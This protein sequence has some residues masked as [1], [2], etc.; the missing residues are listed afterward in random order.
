[1]RYFN[2]PIPD[3]KMLYFVLRL[4]II[5]KND[6]S[7]E[8]CNSNNYQC[9]RDLIGCTGNIPVYPSKESF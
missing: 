4:R 1:M 6:E 9:S 3:D 2:F 5:F 8:K 7:S